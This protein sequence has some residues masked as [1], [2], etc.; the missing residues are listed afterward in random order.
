MIE[1]KK[2]KIL[3][4]PGPL[5]SSLTVKQAMLR[6]LGSRDYEFISTI[7]EIRKRLVELGGATEET[8]TAIPLQGSGTYSLEAVVNATIAPDG[9]LLVAI[10]GAYGRRVALMG[11]INGIETDTID[12]SEDEPVDPE[13]IREA[14]AADK[15]ITHVS[16]CHCETTSGIINP[17]K[18]LGSVIKEAGRI[19]FLDAMSS[20]GA[21]PLNFDECGID[22]LVSSANKCIEGVPGF[23]FVIAKLEELEKTEGYSRTLCFNLLEQH[24]G[25]EKNGQFRFTPPTHTLLAFR[26]ALIELEEEGGVEGRGA[27]Y[28][29]NYEVLA[30]GM[31]KMGFKEFLKPE[32]RGYIISSFY[33]PKHE[34]F[35]FEDFYRRLNEKGFVI[36][37]GK[38]GQADCFRIGSIGRITYKDVEALLVAIK[39]CLA[40]MNVQMN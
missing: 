10:N 13:K 8:Y 35:S 3:F 19:F 24:R 6:D 20:F 17:I 38:V 25:L 7:K 28:K 5:T 40:D 21:V 12:F 33:Y 14:L 22:Y 23:G 18:Q 32:D 16:C 26:Q 1:S 29:K 34:N 27:R 9:K 15:K 31:Y 11:R 30:A 39:Q 4:T 2:D 37:P 36:Y